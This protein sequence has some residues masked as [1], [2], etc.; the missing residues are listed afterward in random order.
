MNLL[1]TPSINGYVK[2]NAQYKT[3]YLVDVPFLTSHISHLKASEGFLYVH[4][5][6]SH[7]PSSKGL[8]LLDL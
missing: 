2:C 6:Q 8:A 3:Q 7:D 5:E 1:T 4:T